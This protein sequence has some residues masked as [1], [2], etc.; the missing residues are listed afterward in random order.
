VSGVRSTLHQ[1]AQDLI[2]G[3]F[4][5][6]CHLFTASGR[7]QIGGSK[8]AS[9]LAYGMTLAHARSLVRRYLQKVEHWPVSVHGNTARVPNIAGGSP[10]SLVRQGNRWLINAGPISH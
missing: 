3:N 6:A 2:D 4:S 9:I 5:G 8:C 10:T 7:A 1:F